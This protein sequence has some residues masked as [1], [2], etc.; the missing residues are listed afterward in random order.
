MM[1]NV[2]T[3]TV[4]RLHPTDR[5][6]LSAHGKGRLLPICCAYVYCATIGGPIEQPIGCATL[7]GL[8]PVALVRKITACIRRETDGTWSVNLAAQSSA[9]WC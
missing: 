2:L 4:A 1:H 6:R 3:Y 5:S 9:R 7:L 8:P